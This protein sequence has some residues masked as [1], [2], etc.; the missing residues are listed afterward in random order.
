MGVELEPVFVLPPEHR[1]KPNI[2]EA[3]AIPVI[4]LSPLQ[5]TPIPDGGDDVPEALRGLVAEVEEACSVVGFFQV[6][7]HGV[8]TE[9]LNR[10]QSAA[11][12]FFALPVEEKRRVRR[13]EVNFLG[14]YDT[15]VTK[16]VRDWKEVFDFTGNDPMIVPAT[17]EAGETRTH[18]ITNTWPERPLGMR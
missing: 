4:D 14:Y 16:N 3:G 10:V 1:P 17:A 11:K 18:E 2:S 12:E 7:N 15:E 13:N 6:I 8:P 5:T 9:L